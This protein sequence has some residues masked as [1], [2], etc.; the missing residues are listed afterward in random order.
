MSSKETPD[1][2][3]DIIEGV[4]VE[5]TGGPTGR[6]RAA[7][8]N[9]ARS[10]AEG[11]GPSSTGARP[12]NMTSDNDESANAA[13]G[14]SASD[15][16]GDAASSGETKRRRFGLPVMLGVPALVLVLAGGGL[17]QWMAAR[18]EAQLRVEIE[19]LAAQMAAANDALASM[20]AELAAV[21]K[22]RAEIDAR[23]DGIEASLPQDPA[24]ALSALSKRL[25]MLAADMDALSAASDAAQ[26]SIDGSLPN[27]AL[28]L[29]QAGFGAAN[30]MNAANLV[31]GDPVQWLSVLEEL[32]RAGLDIEGL[33]GIQA[34]LTPPP[35]TTTQ[36]L[37][38][39]VDLAG[40]LRRD[41]NEAAGWWQNA[42][43]RLAGF[44][45]LRRSEE[46][47]SRS[48]GQRDDPVPLDVF[49][50]A[51]RAGNLLSSVAAS[52]QIVPASARLAAW[53][54]Q[55][56]RRLDLDAALVGLMA[57]MT[58]RLAATGVTD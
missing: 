58:S 48:D 16:F 55:A 22:G 1:T 6:R 26:T 24:D 14:H 46:S 28:A 12:D 7:G 31:G 33:A 41:Q 47:S 3:P 57:D 29:A 52:R 32:A 39:G 8:R 25:D 19:G 37:A 42:T 44:I 40:D 30:A 56:Q 49:A 21:D 35:A 5:K 13:S 10:G 51:L 34:L 23:L 20:Q 18:H 43:G 4:A 38:S 53:Q 45:R 54:A 27:T 2:D 17:L 11:K 50:N 15:G 36:L 9:R